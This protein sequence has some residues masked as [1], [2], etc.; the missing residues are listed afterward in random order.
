MA[1]ASCFPILSNLKG[2]NSGSLIGT[3]ITVIVVFAIIFYLIAK[4]GD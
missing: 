3:I 2:G 4:S 1:A